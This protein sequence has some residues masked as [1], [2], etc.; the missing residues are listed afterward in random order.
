MSFFCSVIGIFW[1]EGITDLGAIQFPISAQAVPAFLYGLFISK[2]K[3][4][5]HPWSIA[6]GAWVSVVYVLGFYFGYIDSVDG[7]KAVNAGISGLVV[8][9]VVTISTELT[10]R[11]MTGAENAGDSDKQDHAVTRASQE[12]TDRTALLLFANRP[13]WDIPSLSRFGDH[14][15]APEY[16][17]KSM[18]GVPEPMTNLW[19]VGF[20]FFTI[21]MV[22]PLTPENEP[23][24]S[25]DGVF[26]WAPALIRGLPWW[27]FKLLM[28]SAAST[29]ILMFAIFKAPDEF[30][31]CRADVLVMKRRETENLESLDRGDV[32][33]GGEG[34]GS[35]GEDELVAKVDFL[36]EDA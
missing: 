21:T 12:D 7:A 35:S 20:F 13:E 26:L 14:A 8:N 15:L 2:S 32:S 31:K 17:W 11:S 18:E 10:R 29:L 9:V 4:D 24:L 19:W 23:P 22:T 16:I 25:V 36:E 34:D 5:L 27:Y 6:A 3:F 30:P 33:S 28:I 1:D